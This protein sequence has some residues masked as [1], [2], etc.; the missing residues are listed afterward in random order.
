MFVPSGKKMENAQSEFIGCF[1]CDTVS[2]S[3]LVSIHPIAGCKSS[4][5]DAK[6]AMAAYS[7]RT[8]AIIF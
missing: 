8:S 2:D 3:Y 7:V 4:F 5:S 1:M 6:T